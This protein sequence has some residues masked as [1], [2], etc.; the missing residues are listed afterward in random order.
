MLRVIFDTNIYG[1]ILDSGQ[2]KVIEEKL[3]NNMIIYGFSLIR[4]EL[5]NVPTTTTKA[6]KARLLLLSLHDRV[7]KEHIFTENKRIIDL[8][9]EYYNEYRNQGGIVPWKNIRTD[10]MIV[11][12]ATL[13]GLDVIVSNDKKTMVSSKALISYNLINERTPTFFTFEDLVNKFTI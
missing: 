9:K 5:R 11:A 8:A 13:H 10:F 7:T 6:R 2:E 12:C 4:K 3:P 1:L